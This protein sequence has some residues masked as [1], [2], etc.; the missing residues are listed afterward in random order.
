[1]KGFLPN[2]ERT[3][4]WVRA[5]AFRKQRLG[6][7]VTNSRLMKFP[8]DKNSMNLA[9]REKDSLMGYK[10]GRNETYPKV[11]TGISLKGWR[12]FFMK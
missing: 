5:F 9:S 10:K 1:M 4:R 12:V 6:T 8:E 7:Y 11:W 2:N 3:T